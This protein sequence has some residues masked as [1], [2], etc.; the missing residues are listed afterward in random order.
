MLE[1]PLR[2][3]LLRGEIVSDRETLEALLDYLRANGEDAHEVEVGTIKLKLYPSRKAQA[4]VIA[5]GVAKAENIRRQMPVTRKEL[6]ESIGLNR[7]ASAQA[8]PFATDKTP[9]A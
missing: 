6:L 7:P 4:D 8:A 1:A 5:E 2:V 3:R 9:E